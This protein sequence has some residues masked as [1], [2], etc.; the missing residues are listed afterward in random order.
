MQQVKKVYHSKYAM[1]LTITIEVDGK[2]VGCD[3]IGT[4]A[5]QKAAHGTFATKDAKVQSALEAHPWFGE[6]FRLLKTI[7]LGP[8]ETP[9]IITKEPEVKKVEVT[10]GEPFVSQVTNAQ[11]AKNELNKVFGVPF[12][13]LKNVRGVKEHA[14]IN[15]VQYPNWV[16]YNL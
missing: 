15:N 8:A 2:S 16:G 9:K 11:D 14:E 6:Q 10:T 13:K 12:S 7:N 4:M 1:S 5:G 3:F